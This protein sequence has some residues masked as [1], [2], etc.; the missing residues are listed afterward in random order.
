MLFALRLLTVLSGLG[1]LVFGLG[2]WVHPGPAAEM[3]GATLLEG[4]GRTAQIGD[5]GAFFVGAGMMLAWGAIRGQASVL[6]AGG[7]LV[8][9]VVPG[10][11]ASAM[12][13]GGSWT[14]DEIVAE[15]AITIL[16]LTTATSALLSAA[17]QRLEPGSARISGLQRRQVILS[18]SLKP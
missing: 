10:R 11:V 17:F 2:W 8:G 12:Y 3:L 7:L 6:L 14:P 18:F 5:T 4:T 16:A 13:H 15:C 9:L 1:L